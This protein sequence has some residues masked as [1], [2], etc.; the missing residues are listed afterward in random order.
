MAFNLFQT[1]KNQQTSALSSFGSNLFG[2]KSSTPKIDITKMSGYQAP[3]TVSNNF[4]TSKVS[5]TVPK[6]DTK[7]L[8]ISQMQ[9]T[10]VIPQAQTSSS[11]SNNLDFSVAK[12][13]TPKVTNRDIGL[14]QLATLLDKQGTKTQR[15]NEVAEESKLFESEQAYRDAQAEEARIDRQYENRLRQM[16]E[17]AVGMSEGALQAQEY[18][19]G[20]KR[21]Q[22][23]ADLAIVTAARL[24]DYNTAQ[25][26]VEQKIDAEFEPIKDQIATLEKF[27]TLNQDDLTESEKILLQAQIDQQTS[28]AE[29]DYDNAILQN[30]AGVYQQMLDAGT[31]TLD[32]VPQDILG[33][34]NTQGYVPTEQKASIDKSRSLLSN[35]NDFLGAGSTSAVGPGIQKIFGATGSFFGLGSYAERKQQVDNIRALMTL[36]NLGLMKGVLSDS[37]IKIIK[38]ASSRLNPDMKEDAFRKELNNIAG[39]LQ[40]KL[41]NSPAVPIEEKGSILTDK[42]QRENPDYTLEEVKE[43]VRTVLPTYQTF[44]SAGNASASGN[45][46]QRNN[47]PGNVKAGGLADDLAIGTDEQGHLIF[48]DAQTGFMAMQ[49]DVQAKVSG[50]SR[51]LPANPTIAQLGKVYAE[52]PNWGNAVAR[53]LGVTPTTRTA[54]ISIDKLTKAIAQQEGF[55]A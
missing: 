45:R 38:D 29:S 7:P 28:Q 42:I 26:I 43:A 36:D 17:G 49:R 25:S 46:P 52:D 54:T 12:A 35:I 4:I 40:D 1:D 41:L 55:F 14:E 47:N 5:A 3:S 32:K 33:Y 11:A 2:T 10:P 22:E 16:R 23:K 39:I 24:G 8:T 27:L 18:E 37:D 9:S 34:M 6:V 15:F 30:Q 48:P 31:I 50:Q 13:L 51:Y 20:R 21:S 53:I 44:K 19:L